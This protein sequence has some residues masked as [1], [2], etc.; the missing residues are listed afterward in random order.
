MASKDPD[1]AHLLLPSRS[2]KK[3]LAVARGHDFPSLRAAR[4]TPN[5]EDYQEN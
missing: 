5:K 2:L 3:K 4:N 1:L